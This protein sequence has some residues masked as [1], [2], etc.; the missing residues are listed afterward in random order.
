MKIKYRIVACLFLIGFLTLSLCFTIS[1]YGTGSDPESEL[2]QKTPEE[3]VVLEI[4][5]WSENLV[6]LYED[7]AREFE[8]EYP[9]IEL[10]FI[11][12]SENEFYEALPLLF[13]SGQAPDIFYRSG[14]GTVLR[15]LLEKGWIRPLHPD[16][17]VPQ[18]WMEC[19]PDDC[20]IPGINVYNKEVYSFH[21]TNIK[22]GVWGF[23]FYNKEILA[24][25]G[26]DP[27]QPPE[28]WSELKDACRTISNQSI[29]AGIT[30][31]LDPPGDIRRLWTAIAGSIMTDT[32]FDYQ[33]GRFCMDDERMLVAYDYIRSFYDEALVLRGDDPENP[34]QYDKAFAR[35]ALATG[36]AAFYFDGHFV[37]GYLKTI[38][39]ED[40]VNTN[41]GIAATPYP[42]DC[43]HGAL[44]SVLNNN[45]YW[46]SSQT[47][48]PEEAWLFI[49][50]M[51]QPDGFFGR[52]YVSRGYGFL[53]YVDNA[54]YVTDPNMLRVIKIAPA[55][56]VIYP[57]PLVL[58]PELAESQA[59]I[60]AGESVRWM[61]TIGECLLDDCD[62][63]ETAHDTAQTQN[64][65]FL[66]T[67]EEERNS[68][69]D[70][71]VDD[72]TF[73]DWNFNEDFD[74]GSYLEE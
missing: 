23:M 21:F 58:N 28:T 30:I 37:L 60:T 39:F 45:S 13:E 22:A 51:T 50:W 53:E 43:P 20:F 31:P 32:T 7:A 49:D 10:E 57:E 33:Q 52:E 11:T 26:L 18:E 41:L 59:F 6:E 19:W 14:G 68:G 63:N 29:S 24:E 48:H 61:P 8:R 25:A 56:R 1:G 44:S 73:P 16:G 47:Q 46:V 70:V 12:M 5:T 42:D 72:Y 69:L 74:Y 27:E 67:L 66:Q 34:H 40:F 35:Q 64:D 2:V 65:L 54:Q 55:L 3:K 36:Q 71:S 4:M 9:N 17:T 38:G 62:F 15:E